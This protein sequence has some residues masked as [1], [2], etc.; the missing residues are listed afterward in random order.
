MKNLK[1]IKAQYQRD[2]ERHLQAAKAWEAVSFKAKKNGEPFQNMRQNLEGCSV[3]DRGVYNDF[4]LQEAIVYFYANNSS[5]SDSIN[6]Y[7][8]IN[9]Y[10]NPNEVYVFDFVDVKKAIEKQIENHKKLAAQYQKDLKALDR[11]YNKGLKM[12]QK[13]YTEVKE[14]GSDYLYYE[15]RDAFKDFYL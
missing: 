14:S 9:V 7:Y 2:I 13:Y 8:T 1:E 11:L 6:L 15:L 4:Q 3:I 12:M 10:S 5:C